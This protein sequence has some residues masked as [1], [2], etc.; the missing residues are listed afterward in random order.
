M[1]KHLDWGLANKIFKLV[2]K[3]GLFRP[4]DGENCLTIGRGWV[5]GGFKIFIPHLTPK[6]NLQILDV[7]NEAIK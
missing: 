3:D 1:F 6:K 5:K 4:Y 7:K 2:G